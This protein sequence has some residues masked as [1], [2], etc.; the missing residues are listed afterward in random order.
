MIL[1]GYD[2]ADD[3]AIGAPL[4]SLSFPLGLFMKVS[5]GTR[6]SASTSDG[7]FFN[8]AYEIDMSQTGQGRVDE[9][10]SGSGIFSADSYLV[11][12]LSTIDSCPN[13]LK[14]GSC[15]S[16]YTSC[17][18]LLPFDTW[19]TKFSAVYPNIQTYLNNPLMGQPV[20]NVSFTANPNPITVED[21]SGLGQTTL[22]FNDPAASEL[23]IRV[24]SPAG[25]ELSDTGNSGQAATGKWITNGT[26]FYLQDVSNGKPL[27]SANTAATVTVAFASTS[28]TANPSGFAPGAIGQ[29]T[30]SW[31]APNSTVVEIHVG[32][33]TGTLF[34]EG[35]SNGSAVTGTWATA[36]LPFYLIDAS[37]RAVLS[38]LTLQSSA[39]G[40][41]SL[42][43][44]P[45]PIVVPSGGPALGQTTLTW[46]GGAARNTEVRVGSVNGP[47]FAAAGNT[48]IATTG[49]WVTNGLTFYLQNVSGGAPL[50]SANT[51][52]TTTVTVIQQ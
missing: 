22:F 3:V 40:P 28:F 17:S 50:T 26:T 41:A 38:T 46:T 51:L 37:S 6:A 19:Y 44:S 7:S 47:L 11:G 52:A 27:T 12:L 24:G 14:N 30:L 34:A 1:S 48:G 8:N 45:N 42:E 9:G 23:Q 25:P 13:P 35:N 49:V 2:P 4:T 10:S 43:A 5:F 16:T 29:T 32:S 20:N 15:A 36:G 18:A 21:G 33:P 31:S 39:S